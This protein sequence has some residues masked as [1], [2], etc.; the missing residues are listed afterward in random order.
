MLILNMNLWSPF[1]VVAP[2]F[3]NKSLEIYST[4][5]DKHLQYYIDTFKKSQS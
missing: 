5:Y 4:D 1:F 3:W 2:S